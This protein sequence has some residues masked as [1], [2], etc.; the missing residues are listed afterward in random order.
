MIRPLAIMMRKDDV[1]FKKLVDAEVTRIISQGEITQIYRKWFES[2]IP[3][4]Q[5]NLKMPMSYMLRDCSKP[6]PTGYPTDLRNNL[7]VSV[8]DADAGRRRCIFDVRYSI[9]LQAPD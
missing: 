4:K 7:V 8:K 9:R 5:V 1:S 2:P 3:P 6:P